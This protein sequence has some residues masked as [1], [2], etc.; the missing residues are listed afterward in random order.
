VTPLRVLAVADVSPL[1]VIGG[2]ERTLWEQMRRLARR[3]HDVRVL[4]R[5]ASGAPAPA[6]VREGVEI[7]EFASARRSPLM[8]AHST[9]F[10]ARRAVARLLAARDADVLNLYQPLSGYGV[11]T[12]PAGRR[13]PALY[14]FLSPAP[15]E[16]RSRRRMTRHH[17]GGAAGLAGAAGLWT[18]ERACLRRAARIHVMSDFSRALLWK[19]YRIPAERLVHIGGGVDLAR[20]RPAPDRRLVRAALGLPLDRPLLFTV[21]NLE[22]RMGLDTL[23]EAMATL[24]HLVPDVQLL[25]GG[26]GSQR[27]RLEAQAAA[28]GLDKHVT[29]LGFVA[30]A[31]LPRYYQVADAFVLPTRELEGFGLVTAEA[32]ACGT[33]VLGTRVGATPE[34]LDPLGPGF[35]FEEATASAMAADLGALLGRVGADP[36][37]AARLRQSCRDH[38]V[39]RFDWEH[40][41]DAL[42][43][44]LTALAARRAPTAGPPAACEACGAE[45]RAT[46]LL[47][48]GRRYAR[49]ARCGARR[50]CTL[51]S[52]SDTSREYQVRYARRFP[53]ERIEAGRQAMLASVVARAGALARPGR[54]LDVGCGGGHLMAAARV[55]DWR[56]IGTDLS[57]A[58]CVAARAVAPVVQ[59]TA[60]VLPFATGALD[61]VMLVNVLDHARRPRAVM[62]EAARVLRPGGLLVVRVPNGAVHARCTRVLGRLG[63]W[64]RWHSLDTYPILHLFAFGP[65]ALRRLVEDS[66][67]EAV[68]VLN[69]HL[70]GRRRLRSLAAAAAGVVHA[71][72][73][74]RWVVGPSIELYA[75]RRSGP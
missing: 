67:F 18:A 27:Q 39:A 46:G 9:V 25:I 44:T 35:V 41:V 14:S 43:A 54:V 68:N 19:L 24:V 6:T 34:L 36:A 47:Y 66:G 65:A 50:V 59:A 49:C 48:E 13:L 40:V 69:S 73:G 71:L 29:F 8:F 31:D 1:A 16:Y 23:I 15:L 37:A 22:A 52:E 33:P 3:G 42:E 64:A 55:G 51:P 17:R 70:A 60:D 26:S 11:L 53:P 58:A 7:V 45:L 4:C 74:R 62:R 61:A 20:F 32:L 28:L 63:P 12:S 2:A 21:R 72:S 38:A 56:A 10:E 57:H 5:T 30:E 75:R